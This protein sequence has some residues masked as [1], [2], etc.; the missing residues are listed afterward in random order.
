[1]TKTLIRAHPAVTGP[2]RSYRPDIDG[3]RAIAILLV[4]TYHVWLGRVSGGVDVFLMLSAFFLTRGFLRRAETASVE[5]GGRQLL[6]IFRRLMPGAAVTLL[7]VLATVW[8][9]Y[10][11]TAWSRVWE[12]A[13]ASLL[14]LQ[15]WLLAADAVD[16]YARDVTPS[17]L[18][19][20]WSLSVQGQAFVLWI[21]LF[22]LCA[23]VVRRSGV[24][25]RRVTAAVFGTIF[26]LSLAWSIIHTADA[27]RYA[28]FDTF[29]RLWEFAAGSLLV[30]VLPYVRVGS[31]VR[32]V[33]GWTGLLALFACGLVLDVQGGFPGYLALWPV[34][35]AAAIV[36]S[37]G[38][39][40]TWGPARLLASRPL[41]ALGRD[42]Y[43]LYLVHW[44]VLITWMVVTDRNDPGVFSGTALILLSLVLARLLTAVVDAPLRRWRR[45]SSSWSVAVA[46]VATCV[47]VVSVPLVSWQTV[48]AREAQQV[49]LQDA[50]DNP[51]A[52]ALLAGAAETPADAAVIPVPTHLDDDWIY[53]GRECA[54]RFAIDD[55][56]LTGSCSQSPDATRADTVIVVVGDSHVQQ[57]TGAVVELAQT[58]GW[59]VVSLVRGGCG[60]GADEPGGDEDCPRWRDAALAHIANI[61]PAAVVTIVTRANAG[62]DDEE[63]RPGVAASVDRL[64]DAG[65]DV[66]AV[67]DNPRFTFN[68]FECAVEADDVADCAVPRS[69]SL[70]EDNPAGALA[71]DGV[72]LIDL[73]PWIC[74]DDV[75]PAVVGNVAVYRDDNHLSGAYSRTLADALA[76]QLPSL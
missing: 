59:G 16:Y 18:Q 41:I 21:L 50:T 2:A 5:G 75:C 14:Y 49:A 53:L 36:M 66:I 70:A 20:F 38:G 72:H 3:L 43:A 30:I 13:W 56:L 19:H 22:G 23:F 51:G 15:N 63:L 35:S 11:V 37:G 26:V 39:A 76:A 40:A 8:A 27:Q 47:V 68:M 65:I 60:I 31:S 42:A 64:T 57:L 1:M 34:L 6:R 9:V 10:P 12:Q 48:V 29:A 44:P 45:A 25:A 28:Y 67:R 4:V 24:S 74:P 52:R 46:V 7:G 58:N 32:A 62:E 33:I 69:A 61:S 17:P 73:T 71:G 54:G 55:P